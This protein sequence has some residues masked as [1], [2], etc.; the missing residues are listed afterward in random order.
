MQ[1]L[2]SIIIPV[3]NASSTIDKTIE[4][5]LRQSYY[6]IEIILI[7]DCSTDNSF[8][9]IK[10]NSDNDKR[11]K[12]Y[13]N[14]INLGVANTRNLGIK[15]ASGEF[16]AFLDSDDIWKR[17]KLEKQIRYIKKKNADICYTSYEMTNS[18][19]TDLEIYKVPNNIN[20]KGLLKENVICCSSVLIKSEIL[21][22]NQ[23]NSEF[24]HEDFVL[25]LNLLK[26][27]FKLVGL[28]ESLV[29]YR[30]GGRSSDKIKASKNRWIIYRKSEKLTLVLSMYYF[31]CYIINGLK[32]YYWKYSILK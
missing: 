32:K 25:W 2:I 5:A 6:N 3:Y 28:Q 29:I 31:V 30:K 11:I 24:F 26:N 4:S 19:G 12:V 9:I 21:K 7:D 1:E 18:R 17:D 10:N 14:E 8:N 23:F 27:S 15:L 16:I 22:G 13:R 20:Y